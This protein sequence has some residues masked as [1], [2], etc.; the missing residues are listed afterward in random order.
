[1]TFSFILEDGTKVWLNSSSKISYPK[2]FSTGS[3]KVTLYGEAYFDVA[4]DKNRPFLIETNGTEIRVLGTSFNVNAYNETVSTTLVE[5]SLK[6]SN[7][8]HSST[9]KPGQ[10]AIANAQK[11]EIAEPNIQTKTA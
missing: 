11:I 10:E 3:R 2:K 6:V 7:G 4:K 1:S 8:T 5:G 9:L